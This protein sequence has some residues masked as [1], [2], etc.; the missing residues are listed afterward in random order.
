MFARLD[1]A[2]R[3]ELLSLFKPSFAAPGER[4]IRAGDEADRAFFISYGAVEVAIDGERIRLGPG[5]LF[6]EMALLSGGKRTADVTAIDY[7]ELLVITERDFR[8]FAERCPE[9]RD[10]I[11]EVAARR[12]FEESG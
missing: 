11:G 3:E 6:G 1:H 12:Q 8:H 4:L 7:C 10:E 9:L 5:D 2:E